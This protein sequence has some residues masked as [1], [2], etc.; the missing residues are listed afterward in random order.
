MFSYN[1]VA[2]IFDFG[3]SVLLVELSTKKNGVYLYR[4]YQSW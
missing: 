4:Q 1:G 3:S 2:N